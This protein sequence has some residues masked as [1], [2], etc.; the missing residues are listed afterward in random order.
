MSQ[1]ILFYS[2]KCKYSIN[3]INILHK[4]N[5]RSYFTFISVDRDPRTKQR[6]TA[7]D[8]FQIK[9]VPSIFV[10]DQIYV[11]QKALLWLKKMITDMGIKGP[12]SMDTRQ[13]KEGH[14]VNPV[15]NGHDDND[16]ELLGYD[17][18]G[19]NMLSIDT[20]L[21]DTRINYITED[22][23]SHRQDV[24]GDFQLQHQS[25]LPTDIARDLDIKL[26]R[27]GTGNNKE[28]N[29]GQ[30]R[31]GLKNDTLKAKQHE[32]EYERYCRVRDSETP[33]ARMIRN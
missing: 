16:G 3:F 12:P 10:N 31:Q 18:N 17:P 4:I 2:K 9:A 24:D 26:L 27:E 21:D 11:G 23:N 32:S 1:Y 5:A 28:S 8:K 14:E 30:R 19:D 29:G 6:N 7:V 15:R 13:N 20:N 22:G 25:I 33:K